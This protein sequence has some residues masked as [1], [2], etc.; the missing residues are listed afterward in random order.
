MEFEDIRDRRQERQLSQAE[1]AEILDAGEQT[2]PRA[3]PL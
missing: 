1:A 3:G 2:V